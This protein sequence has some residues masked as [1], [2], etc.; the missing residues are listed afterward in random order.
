MAVKKAKNTAILNADKVI[1]K[2][3]DRPQVLEIPDSDWINK[4]SVISGS[5]DVLSKYGDRIK[6]VTIYKGRNTVIEILRD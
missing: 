1:Q 4:N 6:S 3:D 2:T 5:V